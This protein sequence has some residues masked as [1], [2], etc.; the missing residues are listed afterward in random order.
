MMSILFI[1]K[2]LFKN[3]LM[4]KDKKSIHD[5]PMKREKWMPGSCIHLA[6]DLT[7]VRIGIN[8]QAE[9]HISVFL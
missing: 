4:K 6:I 7:F 3:I 2:F 5:Q 8:N 9:S 1:S